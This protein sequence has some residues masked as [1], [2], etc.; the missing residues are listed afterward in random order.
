MKAKVGRGA[1]FGGLARYVGRAEAQPE[2]IGGNIEGSSP[3]EWTAE[4][5]ATRRIRDVKRPV[6]HCSLSLP[7]GEKLSAEKWDRIAADFME[8]MG[9]ATQP[10]VAVRH[11]NTEFEHIHIIASR[12]GLDGSLWAGQ[13]EAKKAIAATQ[14]IERDHN[15]RTTK[16]LGPRDRGKYRRGKGRGPARVR[17]P[18]DSGLD[19]FEAA[20]TRKIRDVLP[21]INEHSLA[22]T[23]DDG[24]TL[25]Q[26]A[27]RAKC[28][29]QIPAAVADK[30]RESIRERIKDSSRDQERGRSR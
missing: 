8:Q 23:D 25:W 2:R 1:G 24:L 5:A 6:W 16:G 12:I 21:R 29:D 20:R 17:K 28:L 11:R 4:L 22:L 27:Q 30:F 26:V 15:L 19:L 9:F 10:W 3:E 14:R 13:F 7:K 18:F